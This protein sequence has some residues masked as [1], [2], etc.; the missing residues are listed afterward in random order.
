MAEPA[1]KP[2][3]H[4]EVSD[5]YSDDG[6]GGISE[7]QRWVEGPD[8]RMR[9]L[10][11]P[12]TPELFLDPQLEDKFIQ[13][14]LHQ[15]TCDSL[16]DRLA[17]RFQGRDD[18]VLLR[19]MKHLLGP[20]LPGPAPDLS[21]VLGG[22]KARR[23]C[24]DVVEEG[25]VPSLVIE[26]ISPTNARIRRTDEV[27]KVKLYAQAGIAEY[28][29]V[30]LPRRVGDRAFGLKGYRLAAAGRRYEPVEPDRQGRLLSRTL[31]L[32]FAVTPKGDGIDIFDA[33][34]GERLLSSAET[35]QR[36]AAAR[37]AAEDELARLRARLEQLEK[38]P[39]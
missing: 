26:V 20:G 19:E 6:G 18:V 30:D 33:A 3:V 24:F 15:E 11:L 4:H 7:L 5:V 25:M 31:G 27:D 14:S 21:I 1:R 38:Q 17:L 9:L 22:R 23:T 36:E 2:P 12:L 10:E 35:I 32:L 8:G 39:G 16:K 13:E 34:T 29:L 28:L 37:Q